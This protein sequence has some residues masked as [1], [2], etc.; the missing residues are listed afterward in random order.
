ML[1]VIHD[2]V[3]NIVS[4]GLTEKRRSHPFGFTITLEPIIEF[5]SLD[6]GQC[7]GSEITIRRP[8]LNFTRILLSILLSVDTRIRI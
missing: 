1:E 7:I 4:H 6:F 5:S 3:S 2:I 8:A